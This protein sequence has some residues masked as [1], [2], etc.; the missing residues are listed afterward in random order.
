MFWI[1]T[2]AN[3]Q[4][5]LGNEQKTSETAKNVAPVIRTVTLALNHQRVQEPFGIFFYIRTLP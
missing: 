2:N 3:K 5:I 4:K 1:F